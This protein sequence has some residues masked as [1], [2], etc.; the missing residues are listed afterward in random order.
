MLGLK[1]LFGS[2]GSSVSKVGT[3]IVNSCLN[4]ITSPI[5]MQIRCMANHKH[6][7][8]IKEVIILYLNI[9]LVC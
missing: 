6:K 9:F 8:I 3:N 7:K 4:N 2:I 1:S 5:N